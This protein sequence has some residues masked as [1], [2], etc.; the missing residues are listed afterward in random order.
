MDTSNSRSLRSNP[1]STPGNPRSRTND[2]REFPPF[3]G[4][5]D[6]NDPSNENINNNPSDPNNNFLKSL[7]VDSEK[8][9]Q[10]LATEYERKLSAI[11]QN[12]QNNNNINNNNNNNTR[13]TFR[14]LLSIVKLPTY[15]GKDK[16]RSIDFITEHEAVIRTL[17]HMNQA[18]LNEAQKLTVFCSSLTGIALDWYNNSTNNQSELPTYSTLWN[19][20]KEDF[21]PANKVQVIL[22]RLQTLWRWGSCCGVLWYGLIVFGTIE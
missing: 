8:R 17:T 10:T 22:H 15:D 11:V 12:S 6:N 18:N 3:P 13:P 9:F 19:L 16:V 1:F 7:L 2:N 5:S 4:L 20:F 21:S 14:D